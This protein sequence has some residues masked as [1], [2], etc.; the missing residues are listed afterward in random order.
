MY[1]HGPSATPPGVGDGTIETVGA[2]DALAVATPQV[3]R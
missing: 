3:V 1:V 2:V